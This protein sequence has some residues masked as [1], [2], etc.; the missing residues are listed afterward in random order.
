MREE[1]R[2]EDDDQR[3]E[4][5]NTDGRRTRSV[6][7]PGE[8]AHAALAARPC[9]EAGRRPGQPSD[10]EGPG[11]REQRR[12]LGDEAARRGRSARRG[13]ARR[14]A[15]REAHE[16]HGPERREQRQ[17]DLVDRRAR[18]IDETRGDR[19][20]QPGEE[21]AATPRRSG[22]R[23][24]APARAARRQAPRP[25][26]ARLPKRRTR[27]STA[28]P[29]SRA[30][31]RDCRSADT[32]RTRRRAARTVG[33][34]F[35]PSSWWR[36]LTSRPG[37]R[38]HRASSSSPANAPGPASLRMLERVRRAGAGSRDGRL[39]RG[40][41]AGSRAF[42]RV[43]HARH[44]AEERAQAQL[45]GVALLHVGLEPDRAEQQ[46]HQQRR[47]SEGAH[48]HEGP[49]RE[50]DAFLALPVARSSSSTTS[51]WIDGPTT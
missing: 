33:R 3:R 13:P 11:R 17:I 36:G 27:R 23:E 30:A 20:E 7:H 1:R 40:G 16:R 29:R 8:P 46:A 18:E 26:A 31:G 50:V 10:G 42:P 6:A 4:H 43:A 49:G 45:R 22:A 41:S 14:G 24:R 34:A 37:S 38:S 35:K 25:D 5:A 21:G 39:R 2:V 19:D 32:G 15:P 48:A 28:R 47:D 12:L 44:D 9:R 51:A